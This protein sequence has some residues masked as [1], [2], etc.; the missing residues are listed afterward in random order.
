MGLEKLGFGGLGE[1]GLRGVMCREALQ[2][3]TGCTAWILLGRYS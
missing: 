2:S 1:L 3:L